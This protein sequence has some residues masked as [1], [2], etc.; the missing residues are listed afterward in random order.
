MRVFIASCHDNFAVDGLL[1]LAIL[2]EVLQHVI[3]L[4]MLI[5]VDLTKADVNVLVLGLEFL[6]RLLLHYLPALATILPN[7]LL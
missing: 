3:L 5:K 2:T 1:Y 7:L 4:Q 6:D